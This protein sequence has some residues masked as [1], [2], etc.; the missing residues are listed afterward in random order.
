MQKPQISVVLGSYNRLN[1]L[2]LTLESIREELKSFLHEIF[3]VDGGSDDGTLEWLVQQKDV[4]TI[5]QHNRGEWAGKKIVRRSW[6]YFMNLGFRCA[7]GKYICML[8]DDCLVVPGAI[9]N[10]YDLFEKELSVGRRIGAVAFYFRDWPKQPS[11]HIGYTLGEKLYVNHG[12]YLKQALEDVGYIDEE[13]YFFYNG[14]GDLCLKIWQKGYECISSENS[15]IEHYPHANL[16]VIKTNH[17]QQKKD[18]QNYFKKWD[19]IFYDKKLHNIGKLEF[20]DFQDPFLTAEKFRII[21][22]EVV[23]KNPEVLV[24]AKKSFVSRSKGLVKK[25]FRYVGQ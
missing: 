15:F 22:E 1:F 24:A 11:Y 18:D 6:G 14:D 17:A 21:H 8:S 12:L 3:V 5:I 23:Q 25:I 16:N 19:G 2:K 20:K 10:G 7:Q 4:I 9:K 13:T